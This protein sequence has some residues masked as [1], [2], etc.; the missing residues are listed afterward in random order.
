MNPQK[1]VVLI[2]CDDADDAD[3]T[4]SGLEDR[5]TASVVERDGKTCVQVECDDQADAELTLSQLEG[6]FVAEIAVVD[7]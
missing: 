6:L 2:E 5:Y 4:L 7:A 3:L 1:T